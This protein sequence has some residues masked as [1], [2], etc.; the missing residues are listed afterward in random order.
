MLFAK[1]ASIELIKQLKVNDNFGIV[2]FDTMPY[3]IV[4]LKPN[5]EVKREIIKKLSM[6]KADGGRIYFLP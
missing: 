6:L 4:E 3:T 1:K 2:A 5:E